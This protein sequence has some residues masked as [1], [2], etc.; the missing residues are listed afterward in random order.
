[1]NA[2]LNA[3]YVRGTGDI[4][5][6]AYENGSM[7]L[8]FDAGGGDGFDTLS[9]NLVAYGLVAPDGHVYVR[10]YSEGEGLADALAEAGVA[11]P[12]SIVTF[13]PHDTTATL[14]KVLL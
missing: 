2:T 1:M 6:A 13:G 14:M 12:V 11:W 8:C 5:K 4:T 10:N 9:V 3:K 7:A